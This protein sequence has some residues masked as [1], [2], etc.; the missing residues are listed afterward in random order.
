MDLDQWIA[1]V[2]EG[3]HLLEDELQLLCEYVYSLYS[4]SFSSRVSFFLSF[5][6]AH[7]SM[8]LVSKEVVE[9]N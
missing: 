3:Q 6:Y 1:K 2:K 7:A 4:L 5:Q 8:L 9:F